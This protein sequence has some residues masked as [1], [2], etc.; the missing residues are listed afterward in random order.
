MTNESFRRMFEENHVRVLRYIQGSVYD[1][2]EAEEIAAEVFTVAWQKFDEQDPFGLPWLV[3][4]A[5]HKVRD[6]QRKQYRSA[7]MF[8][9]LTRR[10]EETPGPLSRLEVLALR[11]ALAQL[12][13]TDME[14]VRLTYWDGLSAGEVASVL[15]MRQGA[16]WTRLSRARARLKALIGES[17]VTADGG[18]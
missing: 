2:S 10:A 18:L 5:M 9:A 14:I 1:R 15:R 16:V 7:S 13:R 4:T 3:R 17:E 12:S 11:D 6:H 8:E